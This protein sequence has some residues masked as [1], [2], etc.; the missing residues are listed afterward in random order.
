MKGTLRLALLAFVGSFTII[1]GG[2]GHPASAQSGSATYGW[3]AGAGFLCGLG[4]TECPDVAMAADGD[5]ITITGHGTL[6]VHPKTV[7]GG[8]TFS[9]STALGHGSWTAETLLSFND[10]GAD[11]SLGLSSNL[12]GGLAL[13]RIHLTS[14]SGAQFEGIL[15][16]SC[17]LGSNPGGHGEGV[18]LA[19][20]GG[21]NYNK[22]VSGATVFIK[23]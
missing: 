10:F 21:P 13:I 12:T 15:T 19:V 9:G 8:G 2:F 23:N 11:P 18:R 16:I 7:S 4:P 3:L 5:T 1:A 22:E 20:Q 6:G 14:S 17:D